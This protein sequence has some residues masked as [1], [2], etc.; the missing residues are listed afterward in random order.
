[1]SH[2]QDLEVFVQVVKNGSFAAAAAKLQLNPSGV[3]RRISNL[4]A[5]IGVRLL[6]RTTRSLSLT[7]VGSRYFNRC[8][9]I[10]ADIEEANREANQHSE[11]PQGALV[12]SCSTYF[13]HQH[14]IALLPDLLERYPRL[15]LK[16]MLT[17]D[18][19]DIVNEGIDVAIRVGEIADSSL[20]SQRLI[21]NRRIVCAAPRYIERHG[22][23]ST[24]DDL[25]YHN[26]LILNA[27]KTTLNQWRFKDPLG[28]REIGVQGNFEVNSGEALYEAILAGVGIGRVTA[29][30]ANKDIQSGRLIH[31]L[32][33]YEDDRDLSIYAVFPSNRYLL[34]KLRV[35]VDFLVES[36]SQ[37]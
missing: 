4:E 2:L 26:C 15:K 21:A 19:V 9:S 22:T 20:I 5:S 16:M 13:A 30:L 23:P 8:T 28:L 37:E 32:Q 25:A 3:S 27:Y 17:D 31:L 7:E 35:F 12:V 34:P 14:A 11:E 29:P 10:L 6:N 33:E 18:V 24:P 36:F 1:M